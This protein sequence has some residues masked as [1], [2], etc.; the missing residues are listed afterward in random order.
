[1]WLPVGIVI[2]YGI[3][4]DTAISIEFQK[5]VASLA[6]IVGLAYL[7]EFEV[8]TNGK[9]WRKAPYMVLLWFTIGTLPIA[10]ILSR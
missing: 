5:T 10:V 8:R 3:F 9:H 7:L 2:W 4:T 1:M 6:I